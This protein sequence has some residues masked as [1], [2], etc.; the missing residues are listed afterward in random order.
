MIRL[1]L[2]I[3]LS[4]SLSVFGFFSSP[5]LPTLFHWGGPEQVQVVAWLAKG[6]EGRMRGIKKMGGLGCGEE[7]REGMGNVCSE[8]LALKTL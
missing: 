8:Q 4:I 7:C 2:S 3:S 5:L 1:S 6:R